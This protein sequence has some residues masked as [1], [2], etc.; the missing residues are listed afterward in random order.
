MANTYKLISSSTVTSNNTISTISFTSIPQTFTDLVIKAMARTTEGG[1][2]YSWAGGYLRLNNDS[3]NNYRNQFLY[4]YYSESGPNA[5]AK[6]LGDGGTTD[7]IQLYPNN[8]GVLDGS[9]LTTIDVYI[10][11]YTANTN[12]P[13]SVETNN[14]ALGSGQANR[15]FTN[16]AGN[17]WIGSGPVSSIYITPSATKFWMQY[18][19]FYLYGIKKD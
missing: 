13:V 14:A 17:V 18:T 16:F 10:N 11:N 19:S 12:I 15:T 3:A 6:T 7:A 5:P 9:C 2:G 8:N 4:S 1:A